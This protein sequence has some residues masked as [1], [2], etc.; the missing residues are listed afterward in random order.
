M[1]VSKIT[2]RQFLNFDIANCVPL[3]DRESGM[4]K[5]VGYL[6]EIFIILKNMTKPKGFLVLFDCKESYFTYAN[7]S[8]YK[9]TNF[10]II[11]HHPKHLCLF[12]YL[13]SLEVM[14]N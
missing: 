13:G 12:A 14:S 4:E 7:L 6:S 2:S 8:V 5:G 11:H 9:T 1:N 3:R 10:S